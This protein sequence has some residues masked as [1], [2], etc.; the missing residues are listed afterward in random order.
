MDFTNQRVAGIDQA[1]AE[2]SDRFRRIADDPTILSQA[3]ID[4]MIQRQIEGNIAQAGR[5]Q[6]TLQAGAA[7]RG[8]SGPAA[9]AAQVLL[10]DANRRQNEQASRDFMIANAQARA[11]RQDAATEAL[12]RFGAQFGGLA[13]Q[14]GLTGRD[15][16]QQIAARA[17][18]EELAS[19]GLDADMTR[20]LQDSLGNI[21]RELLQ[22]NSDE[23]AALAGLG[24][25]LQEG[26]LTEMAMRSGNEAAAGALA[27]GLGSNAFA[28][29]AGLRAARQAQR[30]T[31]QNQPSDWE[32]FWGTAG[33]PLGAAAGGL[34]SNPNLFA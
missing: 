32:R 17:G 9:Q 30:T 2:V 25:M 18:Q 1:G 16:V 34:F 22:E 4:A 15:L 27:A 26:N 5:D 23:A 13:A 11:A 14:T 12:G 20:F 33:G 8:I 10:G 29:A 28:N 19:F 7:R 21:D 31:A 6:A 24:D 3:E